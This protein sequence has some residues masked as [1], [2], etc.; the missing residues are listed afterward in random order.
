MEV[1][2]NGMPCDIQVHA[3][4]INKLR[5]KMQNSFRT[6]LSHITACGSAHQFTFFCT[7]NHVT[8]KSVDPK[9]GMVTDVTDQNAEN[10]GD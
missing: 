1:E 8:S 7:S 4:S 5:A 10:A 6:I 9:M 3:H 2:D